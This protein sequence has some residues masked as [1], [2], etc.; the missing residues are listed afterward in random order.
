MSLLHDPPTLAD[1]RNLPPTLTV[2]EACKLLGIGQRNGYQ[3]ARDNAFPA[4]VIRNGASYR[5]VTAS[6]LRVLEIDGA[7]VA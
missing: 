1:M 6:L 5:V 2:P 7:V 3:L 4:T